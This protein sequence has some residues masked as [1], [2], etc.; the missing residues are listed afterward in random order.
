M[1][2][3]TALIFGSLYMLFAWV[4]GYVN[5][6][7]ET[8]GITVLSFVVG[9]TD[10]DPVIINILQ[11]KWNITGT[12]L[13]TAMVNASTSNN[14]LRRVYGIALCDKSKKLP[15]IAGFS[16]LIIAGFIVSFVLL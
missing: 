4:T 2:F 1:E 10:F 11:S 15:L 5:S 7:Y 14:V 8:S 13:V 9:I 6:Y 3:T 16:M 12:F